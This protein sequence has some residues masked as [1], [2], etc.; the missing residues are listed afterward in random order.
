MPKRA[1]KPWDI[2]S[3]I[4]SAGT[5]LTLLAVIFGGGGFYFT[6]K[7]VPAALKSETEARQASHKEESDKREQLRNALINYADK[8]QHSVD[9]LAAHAMVTDEQ[10]KNVDN[11]IKNVNNSLDRLIHGVQDLSTGHAKK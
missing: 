8:T 1:A 11:Q 4:S 9:S 5:V 6:L 2:S 10:I 7:D 3:L